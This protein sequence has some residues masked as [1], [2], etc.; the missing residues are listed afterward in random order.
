MI[1]WVYMNKWILPTVFIVILLAG[2]GYYF[3]VQKN[4]LLNPVACTMEA[5]MCP[6]G[7]AVGRIGPKCEFAVCPEVINKTYSNTMYGISFMYPGYYTLTERE[8]GNKERTIH[9]ITLNKQVDIIPESEG[10]PSI[11]IL[12]YQNNLDKRSLLD[13]LTKTN[14]SNFKLSNGT[15]STTTVDGIPTVTYKHDGLYR[16]NVVAFLHKESIVAVSGSFLGEQD[17]IVK[18]FYA[19]VA[20][21]KLSK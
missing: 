2:L 20:S 17:Q 3:F 7:S 15:Y 1:H 5:K 6:D 14:E 11:T 8:V 16:A 4:D 12:F 19:L 13:W 21:I 10:P 9:A 18:D